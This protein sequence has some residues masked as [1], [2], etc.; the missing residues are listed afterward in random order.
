[1]GKPGRARHAGISDGIEGRAKVILV[2]A[3]TKGQRQSEKR[4][5]ELRLQLE[6]TTP[7]EDTRRVEH[8]CTVPWDKVPT[9]HQILPVTVA[10]GDPQRIT[11]EWDQVESAVDVA[12]RVANASLAGDPDAAAREMGFEPQP[13]DRPGAA[14]TDPRRS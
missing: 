9:M 5:Q 7:G 14:P 2:E 13:G 8:V 4:N 10:N 6:V 3:T 1:V 11:I 12:N